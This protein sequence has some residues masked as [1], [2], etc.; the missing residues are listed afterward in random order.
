M[1]K[2][3]IISHTNSVYENLVYEEYLLDNLTDDQQILMLY[4]NRPAVVLG[5]NQNPWKEVN[6]PELHNRGIE[7]ARRSVIWRITMPT[8]P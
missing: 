5:K 3:V 7:L 1:K 8:Y 2:T 4:V 6:M